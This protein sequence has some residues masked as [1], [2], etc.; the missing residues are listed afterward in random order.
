M[1]MGNLLR[2]FEIRSD[3]IRFPTGQA[4]GYYR[5]DFT[6]AWNRYCPEPKATTGEAVPAVPDVTPQVRRGTASTPGTAQAVPTTQA[7]PTLTSENE[8][9]T[10]GTPWVPRAVPMPDDADDTST[11]PTSVSA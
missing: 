6:D 10:A 1:K 2:E 5:S 9:G 8:A 4:K 3:T 11:R 7:V